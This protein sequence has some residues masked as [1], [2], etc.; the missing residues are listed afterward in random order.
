MTR[1]SASIRPFI[2]PIAV[3]FLVGFVLYFVVEYGTG[4]GQGRVS[5]AAMLKGMWALEDWQHC[6]LVP[7]AICAIVYSQRNQLAKIPVSGS[8][9]GSLF[10]TLGL[11]IYWAGYRTENITL[12]F[13]SAQILTAGAIV[14]FLGWRWML[15]LAFP[16]L[17]MAFLWP[18]LFLDNM[19]AF[20]LRMIMSR[21]SVVVLNLV[22]IP[23]ILQ[24]TGILSAPDVLTGMRAGQRFSVDV[25]D[26]CSGIRSLFAL[27]MVSALYGQFTLK[28]WWQKWILFICSMPLAVLGNLCRILMLTFGT[29]AMGPAVA[30]GTLE[31]PSFFHMAAGYVVFAVALGGMIGAGWVLQMLPGWLR[32]LDKGVPGEGASPQARP[33]GKADVKMDDPY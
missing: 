32:S 18:L 3:S 16:W 29:M 26:P 28:L 17:F 20:P 10:F 8:N 33:L 5:V 22:G 14:W 24:G 9:W 6:W 11:F 21:A 4:Y 19:I 7:F 23:V 1:L 27:M 12:S 13:I 2:L 25:A 15:A 30:I 31:N